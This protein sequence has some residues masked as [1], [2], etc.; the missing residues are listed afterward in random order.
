[1]DTMQNKR[2]R[3]NGAKTAMLIVAVLELLTLALFAWIFYT[4]IA[5]RID[6]DQTVTVEGQLAG[7]SVNDGIR[8]R[9]GSIYTVYVRNQTADF[10][11][12]MSRLLPGTPL[13]LR[14]APDPFEAVF[15]EEVLYAV[16]VKTG[17]D[18]LLALDDGV[19]AA[20]SSVLYGTVFA[21]AALLFGAIGFVILLLKM[22]AEKARQAASE[23][24]M[25]GRMPTD[26][27][28]RMAE[29]GVRHRLMAYA[30]NETYQISY[31]R[32]GNINE[33][34][35]NGR[36][37]DE[38][39]VFS[40]WPHALFAVVDGHRI[41]AGYIG[42]VGQGLGRCYILFDGQTVAKTRRAL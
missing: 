10:E 17:G 41:E 29:T 31:R 42:G 28:N 23:A 12:E 13:T 39:K 25:E 35:V 38:K 40:D 32:V 1:M 21:A 3:Q 4:T 19:R 11:T 14:V 7:Y 33:L 15:R 6:A 20:N 24:F 37:Y 16:E 8:L 27:V 2:S 34:I 36:V 22:R 9:D 18:T 26:G 5:V 30:S